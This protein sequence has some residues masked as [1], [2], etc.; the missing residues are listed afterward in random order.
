M[1]HDVTGF[2]CTSKNPFL[3]P[4]SYTV[5]DAETYFTLVFTCVKPALALLYVLMARYLKTWIT[6]IYRVT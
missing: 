2:F 5:P 1:S 6:N 4:F 3:R